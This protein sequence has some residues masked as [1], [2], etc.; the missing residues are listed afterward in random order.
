[1]RDAPDLQGCGESGGAACS[2]L[3]AERI[4]ATAEKVDSLKSVRATLLNAGQ[5]TLVVVIDRA[6]HQEERRARQIARE[7]PAVAGA[8]V[9]RREAEAGRLREQLVTDV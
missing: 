8:M 3:E 2:T 7:R 5:H 6:I 4:Q 9:A 1:M